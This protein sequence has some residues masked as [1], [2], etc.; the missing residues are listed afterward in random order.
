MHEMSLAEGVLQL[1]ED[2]AREQAFSRVTAVWL[3]I[4]ELA[5]VEVEAMKF[6]FDAV[7]RDSIAAGARL[8]I[9][10]TPGSG[11]CMECAVT[12]PLGEVFGACPRCGRHRVQVTGG[13]EMRVKELEVE[14]A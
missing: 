1:I 14:V 5:G 4:G 12:V 6:C 8:E 10:A 13:T 2:A 11:W 3:E 7:T 9:I